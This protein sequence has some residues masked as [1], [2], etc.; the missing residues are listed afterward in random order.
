[1]DDTLADEEFVNSYLVTEAG[2]IDG[3]TEGAIRAFE[4]GRTPPTGPPVDDD[5]ILP[6]G[7]AGLLAEGLAYVGAAL[8]FGAGAVLFGELWNDLGAVA[9]TLSAAAGTLA[10]G[11]AAAAA[12][13][14]P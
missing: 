12:S 4:G 3:A 8:A 11:G 2:I 13:R 14:S 5:G 7:R 9:R 1:M 6:E 10:L